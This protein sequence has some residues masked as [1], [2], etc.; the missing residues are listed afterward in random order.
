[1]PALLWAILV[2]YIGGRSSVPSPEVD[3]PLDK[4]AHF[5]MYGILGVLAA[6]VAR[7]LRFR[8]GWWWFVAVGLL[9]GLTDELQQRR[10]PSRTA[11]PIDWIADAA[12]YTIGFWLVYRRRA[13]VR[14][15]GRDKI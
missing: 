13:L 1:V 6:R 8:V 5:T 14:N 4:V 15:G 10:I 9:L 2:L 3:L 12:G 11:D 7:R